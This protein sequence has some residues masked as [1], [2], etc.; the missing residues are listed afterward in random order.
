MI[1]RNSTINPAGIMR[2][3][4]RGGQANVIAVVGNGSC[5][6]EEE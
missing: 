6:F 2:I 4:N 3:I 5:L 1:S